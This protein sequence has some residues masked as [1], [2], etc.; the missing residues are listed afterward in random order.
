MREK[1]WN[2][3]PTTIW[4]NMSKF[5]S[6]KSLHPTE[7][8]RDGLIASWI[9]QSLDICLFDGQWIAQRRTYPGQHRDWLSGILGSM[10]YTEYSILDEDNRLFYYLDSSRIRI[11]LIRNRICKKKLLRWD[12]TKWEKNLSFL[13]QLFISSFLEI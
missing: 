7:Q 13:F 6:S 2:W 10:Q 8:H 9:A 12:T 4:Y 5:S 11:N 3:D 1:I